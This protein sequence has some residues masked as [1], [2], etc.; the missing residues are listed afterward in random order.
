MGALGLDR[1]CT[2]I[3]T[4]LMYEYVRSIL[5]NSHSDKYANSNNEVVNTKHVKGLLFHK[6]TMVLLQTS[7]GIMMLQS[8]QCRRCYATVSI[9]KVTL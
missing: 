5:R 6:L 4:V 9:A 7:V 1:G 2:G 8:L 3:M